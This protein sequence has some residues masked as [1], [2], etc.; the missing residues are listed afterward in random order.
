MEGKSR[1][2]RNRRSHDG[3]FKAK[4]A[5][6]AVKGKKTMAQIAS[7]YEV[8]VSLIG[9]WRKHLLEGLNSLI[10]VA[11]ARGFRTFRYFRIVAFLVTG[12]LDFQRLNFHY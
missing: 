4:V 1:M 11:K 5:L 10:Q 8:H 12:K 6:E 7:D 2:K 9:Q 3:V